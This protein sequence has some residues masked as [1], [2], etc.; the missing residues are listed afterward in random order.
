EVDYKEEYQSI[1]PFFIWLKGLIKWLILFNLMVGL[2]NTLPLAIT[3]GG[4]MLRLAL[5]R[6]LGDE[7]KAAAIIGYISFAT[8]G[9]I[10]IGISIWI[11]GFF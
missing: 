3:D 6:T 8:G 10:L 5:T 4:Q 7:K 9:L 11:F 1:A 2:I